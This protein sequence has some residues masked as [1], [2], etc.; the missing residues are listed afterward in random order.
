MDMEKQVMKKCRRFVSLRKQCQ[1]LEDMAK[2]GWFFKNITRG[3]LYTFERGEARNMMYEVDRFNLP[4]KPS[5]EEIRSKE[6]FMDMAGEMGWSEV[7]HDEMLNYYFCREYK[8]GEINELYNDEASRKHRASKFPVYYQGK[9]RGIFLGETIL[10]L[11]DI[12]FRIWASFRPETDVAWYDTV[13]LIYVLFGNI[14]VQY[15]WSMAARIEGE[16]LLSRSEWEARQRSRDKTVHKLILTIRGLNRFLREEEEQ[17]YI[18]TGVAA[19]KYFF[20]KKETSRQVYT[21]DSKWLTN[22]RQRDKQGE[23]IQDKKD[24]RGLNND[25]QIQSLKDAESRGWEYVCSLENR[26][27]IYRGDAE[28]VEPLND[29]KY[30]N[31]LRGISLIGDYGLKLFM[32]GLLG[33]AVGYILAGLGLI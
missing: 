15:Y 7:T 24:I 18:L 6:F 10:I 5:L 12:V 33:V 29:A 1:W 16:L 11:L 27:V 28:R 23:K 2:Q 19:T 21:M 26:A 8:E 22:R 17:G 4:R 25:W 20:E 30:D 14:L 31:S 3:C 13:V 32:A 9:I